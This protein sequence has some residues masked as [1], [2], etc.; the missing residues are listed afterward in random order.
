ME[1]K[2]LSP[3]DVNNIVRIVVQVGANC[4]HR[5]YEIGSDFTGVIEDML[6]SFEA[7]ENNLH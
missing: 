3:K 4:T 5:D 6:N 1:N 7:T 2:E